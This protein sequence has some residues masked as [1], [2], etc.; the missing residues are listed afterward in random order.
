MI[1]IEEE[2][3]YE[4]FNLVKDLVFYE[5]WIDFC[6]Y[7]KIK[8]VRMESWWMES[9]AWLNWKIDFTCIML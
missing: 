6:L 1:K 4:G 8:S 9:D 2:M 5:G 3:R 7:Q